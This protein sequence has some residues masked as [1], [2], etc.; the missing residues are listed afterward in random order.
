MSDS[1]EETSSDSSSSSSSSDDEG[2]SRKKRLE[3]I[4]KRIGKKAEKEIGKG[5]SEAG[6]TSSRLGRFLNKQRSRSGE[7]P[8]SNETTATPSESLT[9]S[10]SRP[11][12]RVIHGHTLTKGT[13]FREV[14]YA[15][16]DSAFANNDLPV[17]VS[18]EVHACLEQQETMV[19]IIKEAWEG[20]LI[21]ITTESKVNR[22]PA[23][24]DLK[25][26]ILVKV[27]WAPPPGDA[28]PE[29]TA[30]ATN[31]L[32]QQASQNSSATANQGEPAPAKPSKILHALSRL[33]VYTKAFHFSHFTQ[34]GIDPYLINIS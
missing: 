3:K 34:P 26:K 23:L 11:E 8:A 19:E 14:C 12:P 9:K 25:L 33:A 32:E 17:I 6:T 13:S 30:P 4:E 15:I 10:P 29:G 28:E 16:R 2:P 24:E 31:N 1:D 22:M 5:R 21:D 27:K 18:L 20:L 7:A